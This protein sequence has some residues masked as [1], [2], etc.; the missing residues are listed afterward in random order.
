MRSKT[1]PESIREVH[2]RVKRRPGYRGRPNP[3]RLGRCGCRFTCTGRVIGA[4]GFGDPNPGTPFGRN[5]DMG[6]GHV[7]SFP[8]SSIER[9]S[10]RSL[11]T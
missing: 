6:K 7:A 2:H 10:C 5:I 8:A 9:A 3:A 4:G 11:N 1:T